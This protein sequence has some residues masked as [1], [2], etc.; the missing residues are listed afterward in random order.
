[1]GENFVIEDYF[2]QSDPSNNLIGSSAETIT[3]QNGSQSVVPQGTEEK[4]VDP[5]VK[6][7]LVWGTD[8]VTDDK[9]NVVLQANQTLTLASGEA[10]AYKLDLADGSKIV[11]KDGTKLTLGKG[12]AS[13]ANSG[14]TKPQIIVE[15]GGTLVVYGQMYSSEKENLLVKASADAYGILIFDPDMNTYGDNHPKGTVEFV[16]KSFY[17]DAEN[18]HLLI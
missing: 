13:F 15:Q 1:M 10:Q 16:T 9:S 14:A 12:G 4:K 11:V 5:A 6:L 17:K 2:D 18:Y 7:E 8:V 3:N